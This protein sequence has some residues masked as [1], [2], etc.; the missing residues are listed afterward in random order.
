MPNQDNVACSRRGAVLKGGLN[1]RGYSDSVVPCFRSSH[2]EGQKFRDEAVALQKD[3]A[4]AAV[5]Q[6]GDI[7]QLNMKARQNLQLPS[8]NF[9]GI[10][11]R[12]PDALLT[13][14]DEATIDFQGHAQ[15]N[16]ISRSSSYPSSNI[17]KTPSP[18]RPDFTV[19]PSNNM[20]TTEASGST[21]RAAPATESE[22]KEKEQE[23]DGEGTM[24][25][26]SEEEDT[27]P[28]QAGWLVDAA[29]V[30]GMSCTHPSLWNR[31]S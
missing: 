8:F 18:E 15:P 20:S 25:S 21:E 1:S 11:S 7:P 10:A 9:L 14:P 27:L 31:Q 2:S 24:S 12:L 19:T 13:P 29:N 16:L 28:D 23:E 17:P 6:P 3:L 22:S 26:S 4:G 30:V 5:D